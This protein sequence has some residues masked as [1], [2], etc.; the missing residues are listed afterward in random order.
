MAFVGIVNGQAGSLAAGGGDG[1]DIALEGEGDEGAVFVDG[2]LAEQQGL[3]G[4]AECG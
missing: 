2:W 3:L 4:V 1:P